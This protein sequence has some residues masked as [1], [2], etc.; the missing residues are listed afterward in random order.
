[1]ME[2]KC[3]SKYQMKYVLKSFYYS[4]FIFRY[5][6]CY[7]FKHTAFINILLNWSAQLNTVGSHF[8]TGLHSRIFGCKSNHR[9]N[10]YYLN[11]LNLR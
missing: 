6:N 3:C 9:K 4:M 10:E 2:V 5:K 8:A 1:M 11:G 7:Y